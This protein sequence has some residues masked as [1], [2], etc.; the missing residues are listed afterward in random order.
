M[1]TAFVQTDVNSIEIMFDVLLI[2]GR[3]VRRANY[4]KT[5]GLA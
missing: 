5:N 3:I 1:P 4:A 2:D